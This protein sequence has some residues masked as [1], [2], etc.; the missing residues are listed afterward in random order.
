MNAESIAAL[1]MNGDIGHAIDDFTIPT[2]NFI[3]FGMSLY[4]A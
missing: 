3:K 1:F 2:A 4:H